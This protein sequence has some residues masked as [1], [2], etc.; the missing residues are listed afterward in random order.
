M[1]WVIIGGIAIV[2][3]IFVYFNFIRK[4]KKEEE[5]NIT[6]KP[7]TTSRRGIK[8]ALL[9][10]INKYRPDLNADLRGCVN[11]VEMMRYLLINKFDFKPDNIRVVVDERATYDNIIH[12]LEWL[13][14]DTKEGDFLLFHNSSHGSQVRDRNGDELDDH[15][16]EI[17]CPHDLDWNRPLTDDILASIFNKLPKGVKLLMIADCCHSGTIVRGLS[18]PR[19]EKARFI[20]PPFDIR[21]RSLNKRLPKQKIMGKTQKEVQRV[22]LLSGCK[23]DQTSADAYI[24]GKYN[25]ALS[26]AVYTTIMNNPNITYKQLHE[27]VCNLLKKGGFLQEP[28]LSG[29]SDLLNAKIFS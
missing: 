14:N 15:L 16:D 5:V 2:I 23:D 27:S 3:G 8:K 20:L 26:W 1:E 11:D 29:P 12:R 7:N 17:L 6:V 10:G 28:Q 9:V 4:N 19:Y 13:I 18:N 24:N 22:V 21:S 25:G